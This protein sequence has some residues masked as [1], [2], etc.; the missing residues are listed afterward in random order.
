MFLKPLQSHPRC[1]CF[2]CLPG[3]LTLAG[4][5]LYF[6]LIEVLF[7]WILQSKRTLIQSANRLSKSPPWPG[8]GWEV[9]AYIGEP[10]K[11]LKTKKGLVLG[12]FSPPALCN[13]SEVVC[14]YLRALRELVTCQKR[15]WLSIIK[16]SKSWSSLKKKRKFSNCK[17]HQTPLEGL[18][19]CRM[20]G[21]QESAFLPCFHRMLKAP[22]PES[23]FENQRYNVHVI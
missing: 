9:G 10:E 3:K 1:D 22:V 20:Q 21:T 19:K 23:Y 16:N 5:H 18:F 15:F 13:S 2:I 8:I 17:V 4:N 7:F 12:T 6:S 14:K 11:S